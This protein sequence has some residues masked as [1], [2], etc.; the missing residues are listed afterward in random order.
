LISEFPL[1]EAG[2]YS[3]KG[4]PILRLFSETIVMLRN[5]KAEGA[6]LFPAV[7]WLNSNP[8]LNGV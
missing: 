2:S 7:C 4:Q 3:A 5:I 8:M 1:R 6:Y